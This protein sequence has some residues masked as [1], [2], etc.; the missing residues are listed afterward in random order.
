MLSLANS[1]YSALWCISRC[2]IKLFVLNDALSHSPLD[3]S[4]LFL[5][6]SLVLKYVQTAHIL[7]V[8]SEICQC[9]CSLHLSF[10]VVPI[11]FSKSY[12]VLSFNVMLQLSDMGSRYLTILSMSKWVQYRPH[13]WFRYRYWS[14]PKNF[15]SWLFSN[16]SEGRRTEQGGWGKIRAKAKVVWKYFTLK[17]YNGIMEPSMSNGWLAIGL[18]HLPTR[19]SLAG[20]CYHFQLFLLNLLC[21][22]TVC[23]NNRR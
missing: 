1:V 14:I 9:W 17:V 7:Y 8:Y 18:C 13:T 12:W 10:S 20:L 2:L 15:P 22:I 6:S 19:N 4:A 11:Q 23:Q 3:T 16:I 21:T 5:S